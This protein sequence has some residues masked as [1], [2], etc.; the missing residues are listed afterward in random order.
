MHI[1]KNKLIEFYLFFPLNKIQSNIK[2]NII[3]EFPF[4]PTT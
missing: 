2:K 1:E 4:F 3:M